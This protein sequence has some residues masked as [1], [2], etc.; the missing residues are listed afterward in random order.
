[1]VVQIAHGLSPTPRVEMKFKSQTRDPINGNDLISD[2]MDPN[3]AQRWR[4]YK[5]FFSIQDPRK[6]SPDRK[7]VPNFKVEPLITHML[8]VSKSA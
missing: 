5:L 2:V 1:M 3:A 4:H 7:K 6:P 8:A